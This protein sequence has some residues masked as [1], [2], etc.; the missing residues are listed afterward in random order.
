MKLLLLSFL[1]L[2][3]LGSCAHHHKKDGAHH[4]H[5]CTKSC[6]MH[7]DK[8]EAFNKHCAMSV[9]MGDMH[10]AGKKEW[11]LEHA[12]ETYYFSSK[13]KMENFNQHLEQNISKARD[14]WTTAGQR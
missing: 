6:S 1:S 13:E 12:G 5:K 9:S 2:F 8:G 10:V 4:H 7:S 11:K 3:L 14:F